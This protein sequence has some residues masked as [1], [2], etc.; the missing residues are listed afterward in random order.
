MEAWDDEGGLG[1]PGAVWL[2]NEQAWNFTLYSRHA[3]G[4]TLLLYGATD[5]VEPVLELQLDPLKNKTARIWHC[6]VQQQSVPTANTMLIE[7]K[8]LRV[9]R[10]DIG[11]TQ[12][13]SCSIPMRKNCFSR[14]SFRAK[15]P[16]NREG[17]MAVPSWEYYLGPR[18]AFDGDTTPPLRH[19]H[20][21]IVYELHVKGFTARAKFSY[22]TR[23]AVHFLG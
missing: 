22:L 19:T 11:L 9:L 1:P 7:C 16:N 14:R 2:E 8:G 12:T 10:A 20:D 17:T 13:K 5:F 6:L 21:L 3:R 18:S 15:Q 23:S 4:V